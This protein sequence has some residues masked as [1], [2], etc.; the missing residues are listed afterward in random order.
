MTVKPDRDLEKGYPIP[1]S[2]SNLRRLADRLEAGE[3][4]E[5]QV[6]TQRI[7]VPV[8]AVYNIEHKRE[9]GSEEVDFQIK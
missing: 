1:E 6:A 5:I 9:D 8:R 7:Y 4:F 3:P 2:V